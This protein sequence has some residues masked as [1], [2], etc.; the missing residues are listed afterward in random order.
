[1]SKIFNLAEEILRQAIDAAATGVLIADGRLPDNP[2]V[3]ANP[4][5]LEMTGY[6]REEFYGRN[7]RFLQGPDTDRGQVAKIA[8]AIQQG[9]NFTGVLLNYRKNNTSFWNK[10]TIAP[11]Y[12]RH[13]SI[14]HF[15]GMQ[16]D[17]SVQIDAEIGQSQLIETLSTINTTLNRFARDTAHD[18]KTPLATAETIGRYF[19]DKYRDILNDSDV[20]LLESLGQSLASA[21]KLIDLSLE[22]VVLRNHTMSK[23][24]LDGILKEVI[25]ILPQD[26]AS[27]INILTE[28]PDMKVFP[29]KI[30]RI[31]LNLISNAFKHG[32]TSIDI[33]SKRTTGDEFDISFKDNGPGIEPEESETIFEYSRIG[34]A[35]T[36]E[37]GIGLATSRQFAKAHGGKL[38][39]ESKLGEGSVF[40]L[41]LPIS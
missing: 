41:I 4:K 9:I 29:N 27:K 40:H 34:S 24:S 38:N 36:S 22:D 2:I 6:S 7:C 16:E 37:T 35:K 10:L 15:V 21:R 8:T 20:A 33:D 32:A 1:M 13:N 26:L 11:V 18:L 23:V 28:L 14:T 39:V 31:F 17:I 12:D 30:F 3:Y 19:T 5:I 25:A